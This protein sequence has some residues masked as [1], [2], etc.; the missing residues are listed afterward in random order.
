MFK[1]G[2]AVLLDPEDKSLWSW[3]DQPN[4]GVKPFVMMVVGVNGAGKTTSIAK[5]V[6]H[7]KDMGKSVL[8]GAGDTFRAAAI[9]Q[10]KVWGDRLGVDVVAHQQGSDPGAVAFD[11]Y[12][13]GESRG[14]D[15][16]LIDTAG[17]LHV[18]DNLM[19]ELAK[20]R[21][22]MQNRKVQAPHHSS[23]VIDGST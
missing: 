21:R 12:S 3:Y 22:V 20:M 7:Y 10:L 9:D 18:K 11:A 19:D 14:S 23:L 6:A 17:R 1:E 2:L 8:I 16:V 13:A 15:F 5:M 4:L